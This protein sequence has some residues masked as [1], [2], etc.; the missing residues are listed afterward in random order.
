MNRKLIFSGLAAGALAI[1][2]IAAAMPGASAMPAGTN[3]G[4]HAVHVCAA[5]PRPGHASCMAM[6][7]KS[8]TGKMVNPLSVSGNGAIPMAGLNATNLQKAYRLTGLSSGGRTVAI[9]DAFGYSGLQSDLATFRSHD[10]LPACTTASGCLTIVNQ[11]GGSTLPP[12]DSGWDV[13]QA[14]DVDAVSSACPDCKI[15][16]VQAE[17]LDVRGPGNGREHRSRPCGCGG[18][19]QQLRQQ[20]RQHP[21]PGR[22]QPPWNRDHRVDR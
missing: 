10:G 21:Q 1:G 7:L 13:E 20:R 12:N 16:V 11:T 2:G 9:V 17:Q 22:V 4:V 14:L 19:L 15:L 8:G 18:D 5:H 6:A 3:V